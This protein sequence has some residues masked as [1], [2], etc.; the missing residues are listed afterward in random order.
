MRKAI[1]A[2]YY[3][4]CSNDKKTQHTYCPAGEE[5]WCAWRRAEAARTVKNF[6]HDPPLIETVQKVIK[7]VYEDLSKDDLLERGLGGNTQNDNE[8][9]NGLLWHFATK[10]LHCGLKI[11][12]I[13]NY[14]VVGIFNEGYY[15]VLKVFQTMG[16][17]I[18]PIA[19]Q[20]ANKRDDKRLRIAERKHHKVTKEARIANRKTQ[21]A[22][23]EFYEEEES[24][25]YGITD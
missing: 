20:F 21:A 9:Y 14:L 15:A 3:H 4:K 19:K 2:T 18:G 23:N 16:V 12:E 10:Y 7:P 5:S 8:N 24:I 6:T 13:T 17:V 11:I 1:W 25:L 22:L